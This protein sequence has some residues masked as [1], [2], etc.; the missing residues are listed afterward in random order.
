MSISAMNG[1]IPVVGGRALDLADPGRL[2]P[3]PPRPPP[4]PGPAPALGAT[5]PPGPA[6]DTP[7]G[8]PRF[9]DPAPAPR[10][11]VGKKNAAPTRK[12]GR[13]SENP[14]YEST[15]TVK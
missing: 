10:H 13:N 15:A 7:P 5:D 3:A 1:A 6:A 14:V 4:A 2:R 9:S 11:P 12:K 8:A